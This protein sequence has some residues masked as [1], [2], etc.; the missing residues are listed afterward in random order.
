MTT[1]TVGGV[2]TYTLE[3]ARGLASRGIQVHLASMGG[4][5]SDAQR[6][7][8]AAIATLELH[9]SAFKLEWMNDPWED[10]EAA[11]R[12]LQSLAKEIR[13]AVIHFNNFAHASLKWEAPTLVI[14]H[15]CVYS[16]FSAVHGAPPADAEWTP[17]HVAVSSGLRAADRVVAPTRAMLNE[18]DRHYGAFGHESVIYNARRASDFRP[19]EKKPFVL[20]AGR[21]WDEAKN[22]AMVARVAQ[23][24][25]WEVRVAGEVQHPDGGEAEFRGMKAL[26]RLSQNELA[27]EYGHAS[28][29]CAPARYE[30]FGLCALEAALAECVLVLGDIPSL[31]EVWGSA[32]LYVD[33]SD[34]RALEQTL[35]HLIKDDG[36]RNEMSRRARE[37]AASYSVERMTDGYI[38]QYATLLTGSTA[39]TRRPRILTRRPV[40]P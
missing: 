40:H 38:R 35:V 11:G 19:L 24:L 37:R 14:G 4:E 27:T 17:Y 3:L 21:L 33:P 7:D 2:W 6:A 26:G 28:I 8:A 29:F 39:P 15:S 12:W 20:A 13:P 36:L 1:D 23:R 5:A 18:L 31:R 25:P 34:D 16:W 30:P 22:I 32:A 9:E 10:V